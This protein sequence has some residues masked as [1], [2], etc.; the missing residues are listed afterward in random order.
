LYQGNSSPADCNRFFKLRQTL[1]GH[2]VKDDGQIGGTAHG[3]IAA[4]NAKARPTFRS[5]RQSWG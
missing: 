5:M 3:E 1:G 2:K 4:G